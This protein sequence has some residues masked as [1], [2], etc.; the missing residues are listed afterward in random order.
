[1]PRSMG[2]LGRAGT[3]G[4]LHT[5]ERGP[6]FGKE[7]RRHDFHL[8]RQPEAPEVLARARERSGILV[9]RDHAPD[10]APREH[11]R[12]HARPRADVERRV[13][14]RHHGRQ[15]CLGD[16][17]D[18]F[19]ANR[20]EHPVVGMDAAADRRDLDALAAPLVRA[21]ETQQLP[22][23][24]DRGPVTGAVGLLAGL[25]D[26]GR[27]SQ[28]DAVVLV[29][30]DQQHAQRACALRLGLAVQIEGFGGA[31]AASRGPPAAS[32]CAADGPPDSPARS[33]IAA[34]SGSRPATG[35][36]CPGTRGRT[37]R[38]RSCGRRR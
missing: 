19:A 29:E 21:D 30:R 15:R 2:E 35:A 32:A 10:A 12:E 14:R 34:R 22:Q 1:M 23:R 3:Q 11:G 13:E 8:P 20:R 38:R 31:T 28:R 17:V 7:I 5:H 24:D 9:G 6:P 37:R 25:P 26:V 36:R 4:G 16:Q 18:V 27:A 33:A